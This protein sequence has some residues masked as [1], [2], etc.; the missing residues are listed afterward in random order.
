MLDLLSFKPTVVAS[1]ANDDVDRIAWVNDQRLVFTLKV[2]LTGP[3]RTDTGPGPGLVA[4][5]RDGGSLRA[6]VER[7]RYFASSGATFDKLQPINTFLVHAIGGQRGDEVLVASPQAMDEKQVDYIELGSLNTVTGRLRNLDTPLHSDY[8]LRDLHGKLR[9]AM[10]VE[11]ATR[12]MHY[13]KPDGDWKKLA[14]FPRF[15]HNAIH[16]LFIDNAARLYV[17]AVQGDKRAVFTFDPATGKLGAKPVLASAEYDIDPQFIATNDKLLGMRYHID[18]EVTAWLDPAMQAVQ[19]SVDT[20][21]PA[22]RQLH[23]GAGPCRHQ[24][25]AGG[26]VFRRPAAALCTV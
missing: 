22:T 20:L 26:I 10:S 21:L 15:D 11:G 9:V 17:S 6:L 5:N 14:Q 19:A 4:V 2:E 12:T 18:A 13:R 8:W 23:L 25:R 1:Y 3:N 7:T 16:P 24:F